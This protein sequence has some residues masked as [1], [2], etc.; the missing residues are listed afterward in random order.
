M[1]IKIS[2]L[3]AILK[4]AYKG[5]GIHMERNGDILALST[6]YLYIEADLKNATNEFKAIVTKYN[7][8][9]P[10]VEFVGTI[11]EDSNQKA[12]SGTVNLGYFQKDMTEFV[13]V[14]ETQFT[15]MGEKVLQTADGVVMTVPEKEWS[16][17]DESQ[18]DDTKEQMLQDWKQIANMIV[19]KSD[20]MVL[21]FKYKDP[22]DTLATLQK[23]I[24]A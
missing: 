3:D 17:Y 6:A 24:L 10:M 9:I 4:K 23:V 20:H 21:G 18:L 11:S 14:N 19:T 8:E 13:D 16:V 2:K 1:F 15:Y 7:G 5:A 22:D 12:I